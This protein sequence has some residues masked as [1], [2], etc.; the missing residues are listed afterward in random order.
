MDPAQ[1]GM[2]VSFIAL[3]LL[4]SATG[5]TVLAVR[6]SAAM[7]GV[8]IVHLGSVTALFVALPYGK[9][10]HGIYRLAALIRD[11]AERSRP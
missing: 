6:E 8:L 11:A 1:H 9:F 3:L 4:T 7:G 10:V 5:L 2:D